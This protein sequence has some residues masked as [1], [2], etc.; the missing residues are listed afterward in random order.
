MITSLLLS[1]LFLSIYKHTLFF[2][3]FQCFSNSVYD[4]RGFMCFFSLF[5]FLLLLKYAELAV[6]IFSQ[7]KFSFFLYVASNTAI[8]FHLFSVVAF[9]WQAAVAFEKCLGLNT[10]NVI[11]SYE[12]I[13]HSTLYNKLYLAYK[14]SWLKIILIN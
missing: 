9:C 3:S 4:C 13:E 8:P 6:G 2:L 7:S 11:A 10:I 1:F 12:E 14:W 5:R